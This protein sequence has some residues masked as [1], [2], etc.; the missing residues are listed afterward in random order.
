M[1][2]LKCLVERLDQTRAQS[3]KE[4]VHHAYFKHKP[5]CFEIHL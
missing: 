3:K 4:N 1:F 2:L 5:A